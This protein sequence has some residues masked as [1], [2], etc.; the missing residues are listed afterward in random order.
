MYLNSFHNPTLTCLKPLAAIVFVLVIKSFTP[1]IQAA[2]P[3]SRLLDISILALLTSLSIIAKP[4]FIICFL[5]ALGLFMMMRS[6]IL[7]K[8]VPWFFLALGVFVPSVL[9]LYYQYQFTY[10]GSSSSGIIFAP[11]LVFSLSSKWLL[12]KF[13]LSIL[14]PLVFSMLFWKQERSEK[15]LQLVWLIF[16]FGAFY[17]YFLAE[18]GGRMEH[19]NFA[20]SGQISQSL[21]FMV[22]I[23]LFAKQWSRF[24]EHNMITRLKLL[25]CLGIVTLHFISGIFWGYLYYSRQVGHYL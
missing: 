22:T 5:P 25:L 1:K 18:S 9:I 8:E 4:N 19:G 24:F 16:A 10:G 15:S 6:F 14:F 3:K 23:A 17:T 7:K 13:L 11:L 2:T 20:W 21:L 12:P